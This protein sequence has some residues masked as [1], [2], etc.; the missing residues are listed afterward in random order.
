MMRTVRSPHHRG[1]VR[2]L[3]LAMVCAAVT[4]LA[5]CTSAGQPTASPSARP[6][7]DPFVGTWRVDWADVTFVISAAGGQYT[8]LAVGP[9]VTGVADL[10][11]RGRQGATLVCRA[12]TGEIAGDAYRF[13]LTDKPTTLTFVELQKGE[14]KPTRSVAV[15]V[16]VS[17]A[18]PTPPLPQ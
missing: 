18:R 17:T 14:S 5:G 10:G 3:T 16:S 6:S 15:K 8:V 1:R 4:L 13:I 12:K 7:S 9:G 11:A 2:L